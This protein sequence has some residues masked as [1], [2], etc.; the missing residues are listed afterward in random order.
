MSS[1]LLRRGLSGAGFAGSH[2]AALEDC[3]FQEDA[4]ILEGFVNGHVD[5][6]EDLQ[7]ASVAVIAGSEKIMKKK[8]TRE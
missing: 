7:G 3:R 5:G 6:L 1:Y 4:E 2:H 8:K